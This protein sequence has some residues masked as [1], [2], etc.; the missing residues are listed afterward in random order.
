MDIAK[1]T[2][3]FLSGKREKKMTEHQRMKEFPDLCLRLG[4]SKVLRRKGGDCSKVSNTI[5]KQGI[6]GSLGYCV[7]GPI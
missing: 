4:Q 3:R 5:V 7:N 6:E 2:A 1:T